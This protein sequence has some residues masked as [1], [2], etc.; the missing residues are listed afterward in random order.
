MNTCSLHY[1][2]IFVVTIMNFVGRLRCHD[3]SQTNTLSIVLRIRLFKLKMCACFLLWHSK[4]VVLLISLCVPDLM[5]AINISPLCH[6]E[7]KISVYHESCDSHL[8]TIKVICKK[9]R[10]KPL[11]E[12]T[13]YKKSTS[14]YLLP[15]LFMWSCVEERME[16]ITMT[17]SLKY[18]S[19]FS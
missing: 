10:C 4:S 7:V 8:R 19:P 2:T 12:K 5:S 18:F 17:I 15:W 9:N 1:Q 6:K 3:F 16:R 13:T 11:Y 14:G